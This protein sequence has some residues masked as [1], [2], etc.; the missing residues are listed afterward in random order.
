MKR[1]YFIMVCLLSICSVTE[2]IAA[3]PAHK[4]LTGGQ[5]SEPN[6]NTNPGSS[7]GG[8]SGSINPP[9]SLPSGAG[10]AEPIVGIIQT[11]A[12]KRKKLDDL[13]DEFLDNPNHGKDPKQAWEQM[14]GGS[15]IPSDFHPLLTWGPSDTELVMEGRLSALLNAINQQ[16]AEDYLKQLKRY[17]EENKQYITGHFTTNQGSNYYIIMTSDG[18]R[19]IRIREDGSASMSSVYIF[20]SPEQYAAYAKAYKEWQRGGY[21]GDFVIPVEGSLAPRPGDTLIEWMLGPTPD[22]RAPVVLD[23]SA[24]PGYV[25]ITV[26]NDPQINKDLK[27]HYSHPIDAVLK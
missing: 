8:N 16:K 25:T 11:G 22:K 12:E 3:P 20:L 6:S 1:I 10:A 15:D 21:K 4:R 5:S 14:I 24:N 9:H 23:P 27:Q 26:P 13:M 7:G 17:L 18:P 2:A 19:I